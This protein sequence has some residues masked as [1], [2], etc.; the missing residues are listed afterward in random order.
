MAALGRRAGVV[1]GTGSG[2]DDS[3]PH[4]RLRGIAGEA[5][6]TDA[7]TTIHACKRSG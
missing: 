7:K 4:R 3:G 2:L 5:L 6:L 1:E